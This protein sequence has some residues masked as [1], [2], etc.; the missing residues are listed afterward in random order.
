MTQS[1]NRYRRALG[2]GVVLVQGA[3]ASGRSAS[4][5]T[6]SALGNEPR[7]AAGIAVDPA[8]EPPAPTSAAHT[9]QG[10]VVL[11][12]P[13]DPEA[14]REVVRGFFRAVS[15]GSYGELEPFISEEAWLSAGAMAGRQKA[16]QYWQLRLSRLDYASLAGSAV[17]RDGE[18]ETYRAADLA[19][20]RPPRALGVVAQGDD[21]VVRVP[22]AAPRSGKTR[23]FG[24]EIV[25]VLR[26]KGNRYAIV[27]M[28]EEFTLP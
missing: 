15:Q 5:E 25:F 13:Q 2:L 21:V 4:L 27:D 11:R 28:A 20:L 23:L 24:D 14:A 19:A 17:F 26:P 1:W 6:A 10:V 18:V 9:E 3:C 7:R 8:P 22:I 16:R 12:A